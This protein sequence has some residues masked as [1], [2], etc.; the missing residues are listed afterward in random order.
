MNPAKRKKLH[1]LSLVQQSQQVSAPEAV[2]STQKE[3]LSVVE[4]AKM[5]EVIQETSSTISADLPLALKLNDSSTDETVSDSV[6]EVKKEKK[7]KW[8]SQDA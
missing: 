8:S 1:R 3:S 2:V 5:A 7:K 4:P 6:L